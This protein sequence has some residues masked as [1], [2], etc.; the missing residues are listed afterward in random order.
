MTKR[1]RTKT[2]ATI[3][4]ENASKKTKVNGRDQKAIMKKWW[5]EHRAANKKGL[6][7]KIDLEEKCIQATQETVKSDHIKYYMELHR[8]LYKYSQQGWESLNSK[9]KQVYFRHTQRGGNYG[10]NTE[11]NERTHL[12]SIM[13]AFQR[14]VLWI[15][16]E[17]ENHFLGKT[18]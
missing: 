18:I 1:L 15:S 4:D 14:E 3:K 16:G 13:K 6:T 5:K 2:V 7:E 10:C 17:A 8:N 11:E 12:C 9:F